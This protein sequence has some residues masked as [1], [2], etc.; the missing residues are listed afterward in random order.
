MLKYP[1]DITSL[2]THT[3]NDNYSIIAILI[4]IIINWLINK[5]A[6]ISITYKLC[7]HSS[8]NSGWGR[9]QGLTL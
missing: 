4:T 5:M 7:W 6:I 3:V 8:F 9:K 1:V 2:T